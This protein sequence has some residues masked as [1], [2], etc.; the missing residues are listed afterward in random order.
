MKFGAT[1]LF[2]KS[3][4]PRKALSLFYE[5]ADFMNAEKLVGSVGMASLT[6]RA[7]DTCVAS[8]I[9]D[10]P[11][12]STSVLIN[13]MESACTAALAEFLA[14]G[15]TSATTSIDFSAAGSVGVG[16]EIRAHATCI[17]G[18]GTALIFAAEINQES[19]LI[20]SATISRK[21]VDRVSFMARTAAEGILAEKKLTPQ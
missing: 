16:S 5:G 13:L 7:G 8:N 18:G 20:A 19:K 4:S 11:I 10:L 1:F 2:R 9:S 17:E 14:S 12:I 15:E 21:L 6:V 3:V